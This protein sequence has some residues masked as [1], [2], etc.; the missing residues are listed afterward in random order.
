MVKIIN[1]KGY[2]QVELKRGGGGLTIQRGDRLNKQ[3]PLITKE[4]RAA[5]SGPEIDQGTYVLIRPK[6][7]PWLN[8]TVMGLSY[9]HSPMNTG[10][11][12][13]IRAAV[14][15]MNKRI[16]SGLPATEPPAIDIPTG[17]DAMNEIVAGHPQARKTPKKTWSFLNQVKRLRMPEW[18]EITAREGRPEH[19]RDVSVYLEVHRRHRRIWIHTKDLEWLVRSC[20]IYQQLGGVADV[21][22]D[23]G[24][25]EAPKSME[26][27]LTP[28]KHPRLHW[29]GNCGT[30]Q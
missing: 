5:G 22:S 18:P 1:V 15:I 30:V 2:R 29:E 11:L 19:M 4:I 28:E 16:R 21:R 10:F 26:P 3:F 17:A 7:D 9:R 20:W 12:A 13:E 25:T 23:D 14:A 27:D 24:G 6:K 8:Y